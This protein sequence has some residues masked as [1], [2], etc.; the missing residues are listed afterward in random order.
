MKRARLLQLVLTLINHT[1]LVQY[2]SPKLQR[3]LV[4]VLGHI[5]NRVRFQHRFVCAHDVV[6]SQCLTA[7]FH[8]LTSC[9]KLVIYVFFCQH[10]N[11]FSCVMLTRQRLIYSY[12]P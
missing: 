6:L 4:V 1:E 12:R 3:I 8:K 2:T 7:R 5:Q 11:Q 9:L 10:G